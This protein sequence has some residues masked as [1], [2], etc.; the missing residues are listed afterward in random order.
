MQSPLCVFSYWL[1]IGASGAHVNLSFVRPFALVGHWRI[2]EMMKSQRWVHI[3]IWENFIL[4]FFSQVSCSWQ[5]QKAL[6]Q[7]TMLN[8]LFFLPG[9]Y[10]AAYN[11]RRM[12]RYQQSLEQPTKNIP[13]S[14]PT[15]YPSV[16]PPSS[17]INRQTTTNA[18]LVQRRTTM[19]KM[20]KV[21]LPIAWARQGFHR[22]TCLGRYSHFCIVIRWQDQQDEQCRYLYVIRQSIRVVNIEHVKTTYEDLW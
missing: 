15:A 19:P 18:I 6:S 8:K 16:R 10:N 3:M 2:T 21:I 4:L 9:L 22:R 7:T 12:S 1:C 14:V 20:T 17:S 5:V 13:I 11:R